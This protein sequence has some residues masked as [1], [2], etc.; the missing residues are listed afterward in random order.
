VIVICATAT[1]DR[2]HGFLRSIMLNPHPGV[3]VSKDVNKSARERIWTILSEWHDADPR[4]TVVMIYP[5]KNRPMGIDFT[6]L[7]APKREIVEIESHYAIVRQEAIQTSTS[8]DS[9]SP[10]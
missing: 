8:N 9:E 10:D 5:D 6:S 1:A 2:F 7:G 3:Y 4:G